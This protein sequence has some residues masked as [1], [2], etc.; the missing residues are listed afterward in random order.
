MSGPLE[1]HDEPGIL[2]ESIC[3]SGRIGPKTQ[4]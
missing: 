2:I 1:V 3:N 4:T